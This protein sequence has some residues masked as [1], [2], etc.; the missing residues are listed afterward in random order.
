MEKNIHERQNAKIGE[1]R[2]KNDSRCFGRRRNS[3]FPF[4]FCFPQNA[5][6]KESRSA[7]NYL[8]WSLDVSRVRLCVGDSIFVD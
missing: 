7:V 1:E 2:E 6:K 3:I 5:N 8:C 4:F